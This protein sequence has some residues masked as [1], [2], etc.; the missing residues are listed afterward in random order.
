M[1]PEGSSCGCPRLSTADCQQSP[2][3]LG[4]PA[5]LATL[6]GTCRAPPTHLVRTHSK[7]MVV[8]R[9]PDCGHEWRSRIATRVA[10][11]TGCP[12]CTAA[13]RRVRRRGRRSNPRPSWRSSRGH[14]MAGSTSVRYLEVMAG[15]MYGRRGSGVPLRD[16]GSD[17]PPSHA[18]LSL[19]SVPPARSRTRHA[20]ARLR[21]GA[22][23]VEA[24]VISWQNT[25]EGWAA[26]V[27]CAV[28][29]DQVVTVRL[30]ASQLR[31][32]I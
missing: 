30:P 21:P 20:W 15:G 12:S 29:E 23:E 4:K 5:G 16:R 1:P 2:A 22:A 31:P 9:C 28:E 11:H 17:I 19:P 13:A 6:N 7:T 25:H 8:W 32:A 14:R 18:A 3:R 24:L 27:V 10:K 26:W